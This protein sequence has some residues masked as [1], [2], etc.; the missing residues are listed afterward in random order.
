MDRRLFFLMNMA[1]KQLFRYADAVCEQEVGAS[2]TQMGALVIVASTPGCLQKDLAESLM[3]NKSAVTGLVER[4]SAN[5]LLVK[6]VLPTDA[7]AVSL[8]ATELG[9]E[10]VALLKPLINDM[11]QKFAEAFTEAE[12]ETI[13]RFFDFILNTFDR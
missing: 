11:N 8:R 3:L 5:G 2:M 10:K 9:L 4:M 12:L 13:F 6:E 7:R 1:Q